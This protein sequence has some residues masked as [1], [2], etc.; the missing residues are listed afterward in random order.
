M[1]PPRAAPFVIAEDVLCALARQ[2]LAGLDSVFVAPDIPP[3]K[4]RHAREEHALHLAADEP[5]AVLFDATSFGSGRDGFLLT[6]LQ[7]CWKDF[8]EHPRRLLWAD[9][10]N[11]SVFPAARHVDLGHGKLPVPWIEGGPDAVCALLLACRQQRRPGAPYRDVVLPVERTLADTIASAARR[12]L[13]ERGWIHYRPSI[14]PT[15]LDA[16]RTV[17]ARHLAPDDEALVLY[18][19]TVFG[20]GND[21]FILTERG[22]C[23][24]GFLGPADAMP[25]S[26]VAPEHIALDGDLLF[27]EP[28]RKID[29]RMRP[30]M[31]RL[32]ANAL[33]EIAREVG[34]VV[35]HRAGV[36]PVDVP[37]R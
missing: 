16:V 23:W 20:S 2:H 19:D 17:H 18:D 31:A 25:W 5:V 33:A 34:R 6:P 37:G 36:G 12:H 3:R 22:L 35:A 28:E 27:L 10:A 29:L 30:G 15:M 9:L 11:A 7:I 24:R 14:P 4:L 8:L 32:V 1:V 26:E 13:G 21:G